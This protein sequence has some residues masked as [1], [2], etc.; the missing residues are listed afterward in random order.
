MVTEHQNTYNCQRPHD[1]LSLQT[2]KEFLHEKSCCFFLKFH[3]FRAWLFT[4]RVGTPKPTLDMTL[5]V[6]PVLS[7]ELR[8]DL[9]T[10]EPR[11]E[12]ELTAALRLIDR[13]HLDYGSLS[14]RHRMESGSI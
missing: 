1:S 7:K 2:P 3:A 6:E 10:K 8:E 12:G 9:N 5:A 11:H 4:T 14:M 13:L